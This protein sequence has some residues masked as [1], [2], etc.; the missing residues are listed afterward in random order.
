MDPMWLIKVSKIL[1]KWKNTDKS[2][3][4]GQSNDTNHEA[5]I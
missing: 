5:I 1:L 2:C 3:H 4:Y